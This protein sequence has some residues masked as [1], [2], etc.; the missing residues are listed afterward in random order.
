MIKIGV[1][2]S[3]QPPPGYL[4]KDMAMDVYELLQHLGWTSNVFI[5]GVSM[6]ESDYIIVIRRIT[7]VNHQH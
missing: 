1:G 5:A 7:K 3:T 2:D 6:G 4:I